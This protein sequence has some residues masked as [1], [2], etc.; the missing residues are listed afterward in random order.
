MRAGAGPLASAAVDVLLHLL[1]Y[2]RL[3]HLVSDDA[4]CESLD[5]GL[6]LLAAV[7]RAAIDQGADCRLR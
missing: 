6:K 4:P 3:S 1:Q 5:G 2:C 7:G